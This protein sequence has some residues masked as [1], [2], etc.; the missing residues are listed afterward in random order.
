MQKTT[1]LYRQLR[2]R[3][4]LHINGPV[5]IYVESGRPALTIRAAKSVKVDH[6]KRK[7]LSNRSRK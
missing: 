6:Q 5:S 3:D 2:K 1:S 7:K 4:W